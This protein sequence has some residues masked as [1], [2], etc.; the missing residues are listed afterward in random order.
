MIDEIRGMGWAEIKERN[1]TG[2]RARIRVDTR[3]GII[4]QNQKS[5]EFKKGKMKEGETTEA[6]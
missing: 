1:K 6:L 3:A 2:I 4:E 5:F